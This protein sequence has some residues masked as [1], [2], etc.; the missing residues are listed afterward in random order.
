[1]NHTYKLYFELYPRIISPS[2]I[3][4]MEYGILKDIHIKLYL[5]NLNILKLNFN[6]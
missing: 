3:F 6:I 5:N 1:M 4:R 2:Q